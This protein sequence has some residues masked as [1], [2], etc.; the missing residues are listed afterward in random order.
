MD[1]GD[2]AKATAAGQAEA[3][4]EATARM[5]ALRAARLGPE[6]R[7]GRAGH[8][9][10]SRRVRERAR[11]ISQRASADA[12]CAFARSSCDRTGARGGS[13]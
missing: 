3:G 13:G 12:C 2:S 7:A 1:V 10:G 11:A 8:G 9:H 4:E 5:A 6:A